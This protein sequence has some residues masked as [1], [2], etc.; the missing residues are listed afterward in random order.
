M[1]VNEIRLLLAQQLAKVSPGIVSPDGPLHERQSFNPGIGF[2]LQ[3]ASAVGHNLVPGP[4]QELAF[5]LENH[6]FAPRLLVSVMNEDYLH[7]F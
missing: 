6:V 2:N 5:L 1:D 4:F 7:N 3:I